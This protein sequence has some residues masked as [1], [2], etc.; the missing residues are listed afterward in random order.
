MQQ[1]R[2][3][4]TLDGMSKRRP[5]NTTTQQNPYVNSPQPEAEQQNAAQNAYLGEQDEIENI[6]PGLETDSP[7]HSKDSGK[8]HKKKHRF[9]NWRKF[10]IAGSIFLLS[11]VAIAGFAF[12]Y[13]QN[14]LIVGNID[15]G[16]ILL[17]EGAEPEKLNGEGDGRI[18]ALLMGVDGS[19]GLTDTIILVSFDPIA[20][21]VVMLSIPR[22][23]YV[24]IEGYGSTKINA[25]HAYGERYGYQGGGPELLKDTVSEIL[26]VPIHYYGRADFEGFRKAVN[27]IGGVTVEVEETLNDPYY[28]DENTNGHEPLHIEAG[29]QHMDGETALR[30][31][32]SRKTTSDFDRSRRQQEVLMALRE[33]VLSRG[34]LANP[35]KITGLINTLGD[36]AETNMKI[37]EIRRLIELTEG[38][39]AE[40]ITTA[41]LDASDDNFLTYSN[42]YGQ[43][44]LV[45]TAGDFNEIR[46]YVRTLMVDSY[47]KDEAAEVSIL[48]GTTRAGLANDTADLLRSYGYDVVNIDNAA[49][50]NYTQTVIFNYNSDNP[51]TLRYLEKRF[52]VKAQR[53]QGAQQDN[54]YDIEVVLGSDYETG[55]E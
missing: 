44:A 9:F 28:P 41:Q 17:Q 43:S 51:Y 55:T 24:E 46:G 21:D 20:K 37:E 18:N 1:P 32:R 22:D 25:A 7:A 12:W 6:N 13:V 3:G 16:S 26:D 11:A 45:P 53:R 10:L 15:G 36:N 47:I 52:G 40:D 8:K 23:L 39:K 29:T 2:P 33:K 35:S 27:I 50:Q 5:Q 4:R 14:N 48:N 30:Y 49:N 31:V 19:G 42:I 54:P 34:T 38:V